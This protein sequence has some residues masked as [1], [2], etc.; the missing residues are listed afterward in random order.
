MADNNKRMEQSDSSSNSNRNMEGKLEYYLVADELRRKNNKVVRFSYTNT[1]CTIYPQEWGVH[2]TSCESE[3]ERNK[4][5]AHKSASLLKLKRFKEEYASIEDQLDE[6][7]RRHNEA[8]CKLETLE[9]K[10]TD[11]QRRCTNLSKVTNQM[12]TPQPHDEVSPT[13]YTIS[14]RNMSLD[15]ISKIEK[16]L[17]NEVVTREA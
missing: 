16:D 1:I 4:K 3:I 10:I 7:R 11:L 8:L 6:E 9:Q 17:C 13:N 5:D 15:F 12:Q 14:I 2:I